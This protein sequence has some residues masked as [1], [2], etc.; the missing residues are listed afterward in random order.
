[1]AQC[2]KCGKVVGV[3]EIKDG[4]CEE[5]YMEPLNN[6]KEDRL[7]EKQEKNSRKEG[8]YMFF[9]MLVGFILA[10]VLFFDIAENMGWSL[11]WNTIFSGETT[12]GRFSLMDLIV[13]SGTIKL[14]AGA[15]VGGI[16]G[17]VL[18]KK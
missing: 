4:Y 1:M 5:C 3:K 13:S 11:F 6:N 7:S 9:G 15:T 10:K 14:L 16:I 2:K 8:T 12:V 17:A 18:A